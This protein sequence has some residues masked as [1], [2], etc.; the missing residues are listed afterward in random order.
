MKAKLPL[1]VL[2][3][4]EKRLLSASDDNGIIFLPVFFNPD[5]AERYRQYFNEQFNLQLNSFVVT[6]AQKALNLFEV[7]SMADQAI[8]MVVFDPLPP[9]QRPRQVQSSGLMEWVQ[10]L[11][12][13]YR[14]SLQT[15]KGKKPRPPRNRPGQHKLP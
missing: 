3:Y 6:N 2:G 12:R 13:Y 7:V 1:F 11:Q 15:R 14:R 4:D 9:G 8:K 5:F 10:S